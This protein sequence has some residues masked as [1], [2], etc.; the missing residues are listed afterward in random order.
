[1]TYIGINSNVIAEVAK[2]NCF[3]TIDR[4]LEH[5]LNIANENDLFVF[6]Y[7]HYSYNNYY[8]QLIATVPFLHHIR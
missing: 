3:G 8:Y 5:E 7:V 4:K 2:R 6:H 1:M